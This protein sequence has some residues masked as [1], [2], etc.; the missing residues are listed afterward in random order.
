[1]SVLRQVEATGADGCMSWVLLIE[2]CPCF[3]PWEKA[4]RAA[5]TP[6]RAQPKGCLPWYAAL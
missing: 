4:Q 3:Y 6:H 5:V 1:M 2:S